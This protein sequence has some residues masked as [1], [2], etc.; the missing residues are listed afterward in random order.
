MFK[1]YLIICIVVILLLC[2]ACGNNSISPVEKPDGSLLWNDWQ[3]IREDIGWYGWGGANVDVFVPE[4]VLTTKE[5]TLTVSFKSRGGIFEYGFNEFIQVYLDGVWYSLSQKLSQNGEPLILDNYNNHYDKNEDGTEHMVD[6]SIIGELPPGKYRLVET[7][8]EEQFKEETYAFANF[9]V[10]KSGGKRP[11]ESETT[12]NARKEDIV[13]YVQSLY[14]ARRVITDE[15]IW[16]CLYVENLSGKKYAIDNEYEKNPPILEMKQ[17]D[18]WGKI[19]YQHINAGMIL[20]WTTDRTEVFLD[21]PLS[22]GCYRIRVPMYV[23]YGSGSIELEYEFDVISQKDVPEPKWEIS[24]LSPSPYNALSTGVEM[25]SANTVLNKDN[26][27]LE[28]TLSS[29]RLYNYGE[30]YEVEVLLDGKWYRVPFASGGFTM[31]M[32]T[33]DPNNAEFSRVSFSCNPAS[34]CGVLPAGQYRIVKEFTVPDTSPTGG[35]LAK[36]FA[37]VEFTVE[38]TI[39]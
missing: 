2:T 31:P 28:I 34:S 35:Y 26:T 14:E 17:N 12:G 29:N 38:E 20:G 37:A 4:N 32:Y 25:N 10:I 3:L 22:A 39:G 9:W 18:K 6:F 36:E 21:E 8:Y 7:F 5:Q 33:F 13:L 15:D 16:F 23:L 27:V 24:R 30:P 11:S 19:N 1:Q